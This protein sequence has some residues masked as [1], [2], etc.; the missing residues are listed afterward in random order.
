[1]SRMHWN[2]ADLMTCPASHLAVILEMMLE[3]SE[4]GGNGG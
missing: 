1:M 4:R 3:E 2:Y